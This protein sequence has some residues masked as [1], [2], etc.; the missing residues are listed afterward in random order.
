MYL[1]KKRIF[2]NV[3]FIDFSDVFTNRIPFQFIYQAYNDS[4][5]NILYG[6][7]NFLDKTLTRH[8]KSAPKSFG[9]SFETKISEFSP[10]DYQWQ[11]TVF[12]DLFEHIILNELFYKEMMD[13]FKKQVN[14]F[15]WLS[16]NG[17]F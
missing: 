8:T 1:F 11:T 7:R 3:F 9:Y 2:N 4:Y 17:K 6:V 14:S 10:T 12:V 15:E 13:L 16:L 5:D